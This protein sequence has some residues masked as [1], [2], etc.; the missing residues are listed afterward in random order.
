MT[1]EMTGPIPDDGSLSGGD[2]VAG[3]LSTSA[4]RP[5]GGSGS[6]ELN[7]AQMALL[8]AVDGGQMVRVP[9][10]VGALSPAERRGCL[11]ALKT[12][13][14]EQRVEWSGWSVRRRE[15]LLV[16]GAGCNT[17]ASAAAQWIASNDVVADPVEAV[18]QVRAVLAERDPNWLAEVARRLADR[19][20]PWLWWRFPLVEWLIRASG[21][22][23]P[24]GDGFVTGWVA[25]RTLN[26]PA[27]LFAVRPPTAADDRGPHDR[28]LDAKGRD[29]AV[30]PEGASRY[31][32]LL[33]RL[34]ADDFLDVLVPR[35]FEVPGIGAA[36]AETIGRPSV[37]SWPCVLAALANEG[38]LAR[39]RLIDGCLSR[40]LR[41]E[42]PGS[43]R[44]F[45]A[46]LEAL[47]PTEDEQAARAITYLRLLPD[48]PSTVAALA[49]RTLVALDDAGRLDAEILIEATRLI[50]SRPEKKL[51]RAQLSWLD[52]AARRDRDRAGEIVL[53]AAEFFA[54]EDAGISERALRIVGRH[55]THAGDAVLSEL[56]A[57]ASTLTPALH[58][59]AAE[60][61]GVTAL[62][63]DDARDE[64]A[65]L[66]PPVPEQRLLP[67]ALQTVAE[68]AE[69][70]AAILAAEKFVDFSTMHATGTDVPSFER[71][72][73]GLVRHAYLDRE[74]LAQALQPV[75]DAYPLYLPGFR[76]NWTPESI[77]YVVAVL[78]GEVDVSEFRD[79]GEAGTRHPSYGTPFGA[80]LAARL[81]EVAMITSPLPFLLATPTTADGRLDP[82]ELVTRLERY[83]R[84]G[85]KPGDRDL[86]Q[87]LLRV[88]PAIAPAAG[89]DDVLA[90]A[91]RLTGPAGR[92]LA[93]W[94]ISG[95]LPAPRLVR[96][97]DRSTPGVMLGSAAIT[98]PCELEVV[99]QRLLAVY[100]PQGKGDTTSWNPG[101]GHWPAMLPAC[102]ELLAVHLQPTFRASA[103][104]EG[105]RGG[106]RFLPILAEA[107]GPA[108]RALH[109]GLAYG[110]G[111]R[112][113]EDRTAAVDALLVLA[114]RGDLD[115][116]LLGRDLE[117]LI[118]LGVVKPNRLAE[119]VREAS[120]TGA[121][122]TVW[123]VLAAALPGLLVG[124]QTRGLPDILAVATE[125]AQR[126][127]ACGPI[128]EVTAMADRPGSSRLVKEARL[129]RDTLAHE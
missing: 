102:R 33:E 41:G 104:D 32:I 60:I 5:A 77:R 9:A 10:L 86:A 29:G 85:V 63:H 71:A 80:V 56:V 4:D 126:S 50:V 123:S 53:A 16:A 42:R 97:A 116:T 39:A 124:E 67:P 65:D 108:G 45:T 110:L 91:E 75:A 99:F 64:P 114:A 25:D 31:N 94:L 127:A 82:A 109:L 30:A 44:G 22:A 11:P 84:A 115:M 34:R 8:R 76:S 93:A 51:L 69:E 107:G 105:L 23:M 117:E 81:W 46:I 55:L 14:S 52:K 48:S 100:N 72:L 7:P 49:Q 24:I 79:P 121:Y 68:V 37:D 6:S 26:T 15:A 101:A 18:A 66:L 59:R 35:L 36:L 13:R 83:E 122:R 87:A 70:V 89:T 118:R 92:K 78:L 111:A 27:W 1:T 90:R 3:A 129:L 88:D 98:P 40:L 74:G 106:A 20:S 113:A 120:R 47:A 43:L 57:A 2:G 17:A 125:C 112:F 61:L 62:P 58:A 28:G 128:A 95:G 38:R 96:T 21:C 119:S 73:D 19:P 103:A 54:N 12:L